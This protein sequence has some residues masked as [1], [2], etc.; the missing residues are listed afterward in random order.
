MRMSCCIYSFLLTKVP[1]AFILDVD[2]FLFQKAESL[3][4]L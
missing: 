2:P 4:V 3:S 1:S